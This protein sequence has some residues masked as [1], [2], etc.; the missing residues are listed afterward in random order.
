M[1]DA[2]R[3]LITGI[4]GQDGSYLSE[5]L[6]AAGYEVHG[7]VRGKADPAAG[8]LR[9]LSTAGRSALKLHTGNLT[10]PGTLE[11]LVAAVEPDEV[12]HLAAMSAIG[13]SFAQ[14]IEAC[15]VGTTAVMR[16][17]EAVRS[18][19]DRTGRDIRY[20]QASS[21]QIFGK[22]A[23]VPQSVTTPLR[24]ENPY[25]TAKAFAQNLTS[26]YREAYGLFACSG[27][28]FN[29]ESPRRSDRFVTRKITQAVAR[30]KF[31]RQN[32]L[33]VGNTAARRDWGFA[34]DYVAA[35]H[36]MLSRDEPEDFVI[37]TGVTHS[38]D[39]F[40]RAAFERAGVD[41][42][43]RIVVDE[44]LYRPAEVDLTVGDITK[45]A[46]DLGWQP[47]ITFEELVAMMVDADLEL[48]A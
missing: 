31:G 23:E 17:L 47:V 21:S 39:D 37:A 40:I 32:V 12:Y 14:P 8:C 1:S 26:N 38:V 44:N 48:V 46:H 29:H 36:G 28:L 22:G 19:R 27:I 6:Q 3:A 15:E 16:F 9:F 4:T 5:R 43:G 42:E 7:L 20:F 18:Y 2:R 11:D 35:M 34:G 10:E 45:T 30:I 24:P 25:G 33:T 13:E 41:L